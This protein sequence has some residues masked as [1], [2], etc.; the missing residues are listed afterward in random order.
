MRNNMSLLKSYIWTLFLLVF[1]WFCYVA[2]CS[3]LNIPDESA[4]HLLGVIVPF[5]ISFI[6]VWNSTMATDKGKQK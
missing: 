4:F 1:P 6:L 5:S 3:I 2:V